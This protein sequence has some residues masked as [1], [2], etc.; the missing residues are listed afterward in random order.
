[1]I[2][3]CESR[4]LEIESS[5][6]R[7]GS[8]LDSEARS[9]DRHSRERENRSYI[10]AERYAR[11]QDRFLASER[12]RAVTPSI[13]FSCINEALPAKSFM[14]NYFQGRASVIGTRA[15]TSLLAL[16]YSNKNVVALDHLFLSRRKRVRSIS[17][18][19]Q[20]KAV[21]DER[22]PSFRSTASGIRDMYRIRAWLPHGADAMEG[23][24]NKY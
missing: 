8:S 18:C 2:T 11:A 3:T 20:G 17:E 6:I 10:F 12:T 24:G 22:K 9:T 16:F 4:C 1:M 21:H 14:E 13:M 5:S 15:K 23:I 7:A 19:N